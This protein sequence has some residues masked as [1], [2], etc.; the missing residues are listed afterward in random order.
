MAERRSVRKQHVISEGELRRIFEEL[1]QNGDGTISKREL[2]QYAKQHPEISIELL[3]L[4]GT[5]SVAVGK[6]FEKADQN[7]DKRIAWEEFYAECT[8]RGKAVASEDHDDEI[9]PSRKAPIPVINIQGPKSPGRGSTSNPAQKEEQAPPPQHRHTTVTGID[10]GVHSEA[11]EHRHKSKHSHSDSLSRHRHTTVTAPNTMGA[12]PHSKDKSRQSVSSKESTERRHS[13]RKEHQEATEAHSSQPLQKEEGGAPAEAKAKTKVISSKIHRNKKKHKGESESLKHSDDAH[14]SHKSQH[15]SKPAVPLQTQVA[16]IEEEKMAELRSGATD[17][18]SAQV[19]E[20]NIGSDKPA[21]KIFRSVNEVQAVARHGEQNTKSQHTAPPK[22]ALVHSS[23]PTT[24]GARKAS[25]AS[26]ELLTLKLSTMAATLRGAQ[27]DDMTGHNAAG[28]VQDLG[29]LAIATAAGQMV[30]ESEDIAG[31]LRK[32]LDHASPQKRRSWSAHGSSRTVRISD[33]EISD[34]SALIE[35]L[36]RHEDPERM[37][38]LWKLSSDAENLLW[39]TRQRIESVNRNTPSFGLKTGYSTEKPV[40]AMYGGYRHA[41]TPPSEAQSEGGSISSSRNE[42]Q[43]AAMRM[44]SL[45]GPGKPM[46]CC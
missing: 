15:E 9:S 43:D 36:Q 11:K 26:S 23:V 42:N 10:A 31:K 28:A 46:T 8:R 14:H 1:D 39:V 30:S 20:E 4:Q 19:K 27:K 24:T 33:L 35:K 2:R 17:M 6:F 25:E 40:T 38:R 3:G 32:G 41:G 34:P 5:D 7:E 22:E 13:K 44:L 12:T 45:L 18:A 37:K 16:E 21:S 29:A